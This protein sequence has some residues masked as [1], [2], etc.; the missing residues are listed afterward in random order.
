MPTASVQG[1][2]QSSKHKGQVPVQVVDILCVSCL[3]HHDYC[4]NCKAHK[5][6][7]ESGAC[8]LQSQG[9]DSRIHFIKPEYDERPAKQVVIRRDECRA[10]RQAS[11]THVYC[12]T[13]REDGDPAACPYL[14]TQQTPSYPGQ[15][16]SQGC[17]SVT[18][19]FI[20]PCPMGVFDHL[21]PHWHSI[22]QNCIE[23]IQCPSQV[24]NHTHSSA[25]GGIQEP[26]HWLDTGCIQTNQGSFPIPESRNWNSWNFDFQ[27]QQGYNVGN[28]GGET[29]GIDYQQDDQD[30]YPQRQFAQAFTGEEDPQATDFD[31]TY[32]P[33]S[34]S[35]AQGTSGSLYDSGASFPGQHNTSAQW[36]HT[37]RLH[38]T[39]LYD[40]SPEIEYAQRTSETEPSNHRAYDP[41]NQHYSSR[42]YGQGPY[43]E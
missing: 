18:Q 3:E 10:L 32:D 29:A 40:Q 7:L 28:Y 11:H 15:C 26:N 14:A 41:Y 6:N 16:R 19:V 35:Y 1:E 9:C 34:R 2:C 36:A 8:P 20:L 25:T 4:R 23:N 33:R 5:N 21:L 42:W 17:G 38:D 22:C 13:C 31:R 43:G 24:S 12:G 39:A 30:Q 37:T 27:G